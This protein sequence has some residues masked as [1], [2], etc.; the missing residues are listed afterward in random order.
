[1][2]NTMARTSIRSL[3]ILFLTLTAFSLPCIPGMA[4]GNFAKPG[5]ITSVGQSSDI[6]IVKVLLNTKLKLGL[7]VSPLAQPADI[8]KMKTL[9]VVLGASTKGLG[10]A[11]INL[12][13][14]ME[15][16]KALVK[17]AKDGGVRILAL[18]VGG[19]ARRG[20]SSNDLAELVVPE[21]RHVVVV[22]SGNKDKGFNAMA[23]KRN[24]PV[25]EAANLA[26]AGDLVA[27]LF[28]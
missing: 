1:M 19:E 16:T 28:K 7:E 21:A 22:A 20:K 5:M 18:H 27:S 26:A 23:S 17:A 15:R 10:A 14:E 6:A 25:S 3:K 11:G 8:A 24:V 2:E 12:D 9:I 13:Q 4:Q